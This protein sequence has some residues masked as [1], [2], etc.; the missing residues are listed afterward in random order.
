M[1]CNGNKLNLSKIFPVKLTFRVLLHEGQ[2]SSTKSAGSWKQLTIR[3][4]LCP[5]LGPKLT[6]CTIKCPW[7]CLLSFSNCKK[8]D[9]VA[10]SLK[11]AIL[12]CGVLCADGSVGPGNEASFIRFITAVANS[13]QLLGLVWAWSISLNNTSLHYRP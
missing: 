9:N 10:G 12:K 8:L 6:R 2:D 4:H 7:N 5:S 13:A 3:I 1:L 11:K